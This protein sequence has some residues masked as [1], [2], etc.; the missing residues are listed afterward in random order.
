[1]FEPARVNQH[2]HKEI[3][4]Q[5][6][7]FLY[8]DASNISQNI[9][10]ICIS[11]NLQPGCWIWSRFDKTFKKSKLQ[12]KKHQQNVFLEILFLIKKGGHGCRFWTRYL[13]LDSTLLA[14]YFT[15]TYVD[16]GN[17]EV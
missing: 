16:L 13:I 1:M 17:K 9:V 3:W 2:A 10:E 6:F 15:P 14:E 8:Y 7:P 11:Q 4:P 5:I 12:F